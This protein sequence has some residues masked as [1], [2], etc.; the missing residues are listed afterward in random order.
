[1]CK[2]FLTTKDT[3]ITKD[4]QSFLYDLCTFFVSFVPFAV[5]IFLTTKDTKDSQSFLYDLC[6]FFVSF[7]SFVVQKVCNRSETRNGDLSSVY[8]SKIKG[9]ITGRR[10]MVKLK[11]FLKSLCIRERI[12]SIR[13]A[14]SGFTSSTTSRITQIA[15]S[16]R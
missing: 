13:F 15:S 11:Y 2:F 9:R 10:L 3:K 5:N 1:M 7:V 6:T 12:S 8:T 14:V 4:S 16:S